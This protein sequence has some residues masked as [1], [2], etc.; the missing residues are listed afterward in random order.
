M[1][2]KITLADPEHRVPFPGQ[3][4]RFL[5]GNE[6]LTV[7]SLDPLWAEMLRDGSVISVPDEEPAALPAVKTP[8]KKES[9]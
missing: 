2:T 3:P 1:Q 5:T 7:N 4:G 6:T 9:L 8:S